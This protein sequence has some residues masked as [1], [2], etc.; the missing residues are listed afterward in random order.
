MNLPRK[1]INLM[2]GAVVLGVL[3]AGI[4]LAAVPVYM[5]STDLDA[6]REQAKS[7]N[8]VRAV[9]VEVLRNQAT[10]RASLDAD[11]TSLQGQIPSSR[12]VDTI[13]QAAVAAARRVD[14]TL[15][16][17]K[18]SDSA[19]FVVADGSEPSAAPAS[20]KS[21]SSS[22]AAGGTATNQAESEQVRVVFTVR[23]ASI[24]KVTEFLAG[25][26]QEP[27]LLRVDMVSV[28]D[29]SIGDQMLATVTADA[30]VRNA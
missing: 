15:V 30:F 11:V 8:D 12:S 25:L 16:T 6:Q 4:T 22:S 19:A 18:V 9:Q 29:T 10:Q 7:A 27:R 13:L 26:Q 24:D 20:A 5:A 1:L 17:M 23:A 14:A 28:D 21:T 2:G 3:V